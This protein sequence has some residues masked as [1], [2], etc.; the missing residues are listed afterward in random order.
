MHNTRLINALVCLLSAF[1]LGMPVTGY[2]FP[3]QFGLSPDNSNEFV[4]NTI[5][6]AKKEILLNIYE[7][8]NE[9]I[10][11][12][13]IERLGAEVSIIMLIEGK[14]VNPIT[15]GSKKI[16]SMIQAG[17]D[18]QK[19]AK[20]HIFMMTGEKNG[21]KRRFVFDHA[22]YLVL[23]SNRVYIT[24]EN[25]SKSGHPVAGTVGNRG[26]Q[27]LLESPEFAK[28]LT[29][30]FNSDINPS[31][32]DIV[33][34]K[35]LFHPD[36]ESLR[37]DLG[38]TQPHL[39]STTGKGDVAQADLVTSPNSEKAVVDLIHSA[40]KNLEVEFMSLPS[41]WLVDN[42]QRKPSP[43][44][45]EL[46]Q[47]A[48]NGVDIKVLLND[49][50]VFASSVPPNHKPKANEI[51]AQYLLDTTKCFAHPIVAR[52]VDVKAV[53]ITYIHNKGILVDGEK[54]FVS[55]INGTQN[56]VMNNREVGVILSS[57]DAASYYA[58]AFDSDWKNSPAIAAG[59]GACR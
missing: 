44:V 30:I 23:D 40:Q 59:G 13:L 4:I 55:S 35:S 1:L 7:F 28:K 53:G 6:S 22:K 51:T 27:T 8:E 38:A 25:F 41:T 56:S 39:N 16:F 46:V 29:D 10:A 33:D 18:A 57:P 49:E 31:F 5:H 48:K 19:S 32:G 26:W 2:S 17:M 47:R 58:K 42:T 15:A 11:R 12:A 54:A 43:F 21:G 50:W 34:F 24:S 37:D 36:L 3:A 52:I 45:D 20:S 9:S 14:P